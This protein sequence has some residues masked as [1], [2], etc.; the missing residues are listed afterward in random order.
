MVGLIAGNWKMNGGIP[1]ARARAAAIAE[2]V[3]AS[4]PS[5]EVALCPPSALLSDV[6]RAIDGSPVALGAQDCH[7]AKKG[8]HTGDTS[9]DL[10]AEFHCRYVIVGHSE[11]RTDHGETDEFVR[12]KAA[13]AI[14][15]GICP[16]I[17]VG[18]T[19]KERDEGKTA[20]V[21]ARQ[22]ANSVPKA[23]LAPSTVIAYEPVWAI[24]TGRTPTI[25]EI[26]EVH[27][28]IRDLFTAQ[29]GGGDGLR[30]LYGGSVKGSNAVQVLAAQ[31]VDGALVGGASLDVEDFWKIITACPAR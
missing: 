9:A 16:I 4:K 1:S 8:A 21:I 15:A 3:T 19:E 7:P 25:A 28:Q 14:D 24:G 31:G 5:A 29:Q 11:R 12:G 6:A 13:A 22:I 23:A 10:L 30:I 17:C 18:E 2:R 26:E 20:A 27:R